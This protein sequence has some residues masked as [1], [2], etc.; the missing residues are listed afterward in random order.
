[1]KLKELTRKIIAFRDARDWKQFHSPKDVALSPVLE[2]A[3]LMEHFQWKNKAADAK[4]GLCDRRKQTPVI[5]ARKHGILIG[6]V[7][8]E[9]TAG[10]GM[11]WR[12]L[13]RENELT[14]TL[15]A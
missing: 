11:R 4:R 3:E 12:F 6:R 15:A 2:A 13:S 7:Y 14:L 5:E 1:M 8:R 9:L 10:D